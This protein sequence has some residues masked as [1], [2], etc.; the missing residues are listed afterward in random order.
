MLVN[1]KIIQFAA[2]VKHSFPYMD[3][4]NENYLII[5]YYWLLNNMLIMNGQHKC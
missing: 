5:I 2:S 3:V 4:Y 1:R